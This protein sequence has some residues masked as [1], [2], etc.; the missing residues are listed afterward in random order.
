[1]RDQV[2]LTRS[3]SL[4]GIIQTDKTPTMELRYGLDFHCHPRPFPGRSVE[5]RGREGTETRRAREKEN[6][7]PQF[8]K[9]LWF[10]IRRPEP[11]QALRL[12]VQVILSRLNYLNQKYINKGEQPDNN[13]STCVKWNLREMSKILAN[14]EVLFKGRYKNDVNGRGE[15]GGRAEWQR[16]SVT[17]DEWVRGFCTHPIEYHCI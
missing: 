14:S 6:V 5:G 13:S 1:M 11:S 17:D 15:D 2:S 7:S 16:N 9:P 3:L 8:Q 4:S 10:R 12:V